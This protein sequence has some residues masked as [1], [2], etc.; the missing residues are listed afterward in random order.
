MFHSFLVRFHI[1]SSSNQWKL[2][3]SVL[4]LSFPPPPPPT[5]SCCSS[6]MPAL[7]ETYLQFQKRNRREIRNRTKARVDQLLQRSSSCNQAEAEETDPATLSPLSCSSPA[8]LSPAPQV[9]D[10]KFVV[11]VVLLFFILLAQLLVIFRNEG[12]K[13]TF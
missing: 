10:Y 13:K 11:I 12:S 2:N 4:L 8:P 6:F 1:Y 9:P 7:K 3:H 5:T